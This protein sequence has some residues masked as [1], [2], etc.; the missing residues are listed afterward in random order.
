MTVEEIKARIVPAELKFSASR[1]GGPGGQNVNKV[2][3]RVEL[4]FN[5]AD[6]PSLSKGEKEMLM[7]LLKNRINAEGELLIVSQSERSQLLN[8]QKA[9]ERFYRIIASALTE[10]PVRKPT[11]PTAA[12]KMKRIEKKKVRAKIKN[13]RKEPGRSDE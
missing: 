12:S 4:R 9:E 6:S 5:V 11:K 10:K 13:L 8:R 7:I 3:T 2:N 1:S